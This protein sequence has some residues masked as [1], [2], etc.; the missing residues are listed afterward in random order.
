[1]FLLLLSQGGSFSSPIPKSRSTD[2]FH[3]YITVVFLT[4]VCC[5]LS[6]PFSS[7]CYHF[8]S[9][10]SCVPSLDIFFPGSFVLSFDFLVDVFSFS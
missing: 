6:P 7:P 1:M 9:T 4:L 8:S 5:V 2:N 10:L 3:G